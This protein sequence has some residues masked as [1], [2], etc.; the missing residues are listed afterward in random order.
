MSKLA[1][2][3]LMMIGMA[4]AAAPP[5]T[6]QTGGPVYELRTYT[7]LEGRLP[8]LVA[9]FRN[10]TVGIF[11]K[12]GI[13]S[14]GYW[15]PADPPKSQNT[16]YFILRHKSREAATASWAAFWKDPE[17]LKV[18]ADSEASGKIVDKMES[19]FMTPTDFSKLK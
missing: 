5:A 11:Q 14:V 2:V 7:T 19:V 8:A 12:H 1:L 17:W 18:Q 4:V 16:L 6:A 3:G 9:R 15:A 10:H 13:E